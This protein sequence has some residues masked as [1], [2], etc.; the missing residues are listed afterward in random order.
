MKCPGCG[1]ELEDGKLLCE[2]CGYEINIVPDFDIELEDKLKESISDMME[3]MA[4]EGMVKR[5]PDRTPADSFEEEIKDAVQEY[6]PKNPIHLSRIKKAVIALA[7]FGVVAGGTSV[8]AVHMVEDYR[9]NSFDYQY[10]Q[11]VGCA[12]HN[13]YSEA[14]SYLERALAI[15]SEDLDV[16]FLLAEYYEKNGQQQSTVSLLEEL[17]DADASYEKRDEVYDRLLRIYEAQNDYDEISTILE[18]C[19]I[20]QIVLKYNKYTAQK[21]EFNKQGGVYDEVIS[22][23]LKGN[24]QG[25]VYYTLD[26]TEP[27]DA[28][29][30]YETPILLESGEYTIKAVFVNAYGMKSEVETQSYYINLS[31]PESP[32]IQPES[33]TYAEPVLI[34]VFRDYGTKVYYT[35]DGS[36]PTQNSFK[37]SDPIEMPYGIS[38]FSFIA[39]DESGLRSQVVRRTYQLEAQAVFDAELALQVLRNNLWADGRLLDAD[40]N[41]P[42]K[43]GRNEYEVRNLY[44]TN[45]AVYYIVYEKYIDLMGEGSDTSA[46]YAIDANTAKLYQAYKVDEGKYNLQLFAEPE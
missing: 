25:V 18:E 14:V 9:Y 1:I 31:A 42:N 20:P 32:V 46:I 16:R 3:D 26:G 22:I 27:T 34:E 33:G 6:F 19:D 45:E 41:L 37:Y 7:V 17:L 5:D 44:K 36:V 24:T 30:V 13:N 39:M 12:A 23:A 38:N 11:A 15:N 8:L 10:D 28:S 29:S 40:G 2:N 21:P 43:P 35:T 4:G